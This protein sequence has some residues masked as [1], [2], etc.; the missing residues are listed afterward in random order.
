MRFDLAS[1]DHKAWCV[2][3]YERARASE[4]YDK[5]SFFLFYSI[6]LG[7]YMYMRE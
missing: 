1:L 5:M 4:R 2:Y 6:L 3:V 7:A